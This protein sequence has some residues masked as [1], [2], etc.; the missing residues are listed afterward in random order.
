[1]MEDFWTNI[2]LREIISKVSIS[3]IIAFCALSVSVFG[4]RQQKKGNDTFKESLMSDAY[5][6][7]QE[8]INSLNNIENSLFSVSRLTIGGINI[9]PD[10]GKF[11]EYRTKDRF[12]EG[13]IHRMKSSQRAGESICRNVN[14]LMRLDSELGKLSYY[15]SKKNNQ[16][17]KKLMDLGLQIDGSIQRYVKFVFDYFDDEELCTGMRL[18]RH[19]IPNNEMSIKTILENELTNSLKEIYTMSDQLSKICQE[20]NKNKISDLYQYK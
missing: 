20:L 5:N 8:F 15:L 11:L 13:V 9:T 19:I 17:L 10:Y 18:S 12:R 3:D 1:M 6:K 16:T 7:S 14:A 4:Y 2:K